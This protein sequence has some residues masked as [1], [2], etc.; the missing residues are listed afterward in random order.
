MSTDA[1]EDLGVAPVAK[2]PT[3]AQLASDGVKTKLVYG[4]GTDQ[5]QIKEWAGRLVIVQP[6]KLEHGVKSQFAGNPPGDRMSVNITVLD[7]PPITQVI[8]KDGEVTYT[9][10]EPLVPGQNAVLPAMYTSHTVIIGQLKPLMVNGEN[11]PGKLTFGRLF[12]LNPKPGSTNK[13]WALG[14]PVDAKQAAA[15]QKA[16]LEWVKA[17]PEPDP[18]E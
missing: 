15:D 13:P 4:K 1:F 9:F 12:K 6:V 3:I 11:A 10:P 18:F 14:R 5:E 17:H 8:D 7:G 2:F 16:A